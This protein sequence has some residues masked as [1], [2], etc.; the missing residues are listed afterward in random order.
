MRTGHERTLAIMSAKRAA[1]KIAKKGATRRPVKK[2]AGSKRA[3][4]TARKSSARP[5]PKQSPLKGMPVDRWIAAKAR[6]WQGDVVRA[7]VALVRDTAPDSVASI[8]WGQPVFES[9][10]PFAW[11]RASKAHVSFGFWRG[12]EMSDP[13]KLLEGDGDRMRHVKIGSREAV[14]PRLL[15]SYVQEAVDLN[16]AKGDPTRD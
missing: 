16:D 7:L 15:A 4:A 8:K 5:T 6:G 1:K 13:R 2:A 14:D 9:N 11:V 10:G 3:K 12:A